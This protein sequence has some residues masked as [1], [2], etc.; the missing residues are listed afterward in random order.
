MRQIVPGVIVLAMFSVLLLRSVQLRV[1]LWNAALPSASGEGPSTQGE[2]RR[3]LPTAG[4]FGSDAR[5]RGPA[6]GGPRSGGF[7]QRGFAAGR[8]RP[9]GF[10]PGG[11]RP[12]RGEEGPTPGRQLAPGDVPVYPDR[13]LYDPDVIHTLFLDFENPDWETELESFQ[14]TD[15]HVLVRLTVDSRSYENVGVRS[16]GSTAYTAVPRGRKRPLNLSLD[17]V[18]KDQRLDGYRTLSLLNADGD[19]SFLRSVLYNRIARDYLPAPKCNLVRVVINGESWGVYVNQQPFHADFAQE[20]FGE[21]QGAQWKVP[22][23]F[24]GAAAL[25]DRGDDPDQYR[26]LYELESEDRPEAWGKLVELCQAL[27]RMPDDQLATE[28]DRL[29]NVDRALWF[30]ALENVLGDDDG[31]LS[32]G[33]DYAMY[34]D[35]RYGRFHLLPL[36]SNHTFRS[37]QGRGFFGGGWSPGLDPLARADAATRPLLRRLLGRRDLR[38]RYLAHVRTI[39]EQWLDW[40]VLGPVCEGY[41]QLIDSEVQ[42]DTRKVATYEEF[43]DAATA[44]PP[45]GRHPFG[46]PPGLKVY[47]DARREF[48]L[49]H[50]EI[51]RPTP[52]ITAVS[53]APA[54]GG[55]RSAA[56]LVVS[57]VVRGDEEPAAV[58]LHAASAPGAPFRA[59]RMFDDGSHGDQRPGDGTWTAT[60]SAPRRGGELRYYVEARAVP[61]LGTAVFH[62]RST[63][64]GAHRYPVLER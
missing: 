51:C 24:S 32:R 6:A 18:D 45:A 26:R 11:P 17:L 42:A 40:Q 52:S 1:R 23:N 20:W 14:H 16:G 63:E 33:S 27:N 8:R 60:I 61:E 4:R 9:G 10:G 37:P 31:Y 41:W 28:L 12:A 56:E 7:G 35:E 2:L 19:P 25:M 47:A 64:L 39:A 59:T 48:L 22:V 3:Q 44:S 55:G 5:R 49:Q 34:Q 15:V 57:A 46:V 21:C 13:D 62:P 53:A 29:L 36:D 30:L 38:A 50:P 54:A 43:R 58:I